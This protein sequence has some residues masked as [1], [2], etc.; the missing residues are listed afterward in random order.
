MP[1]VTDSPRKIPKQLKQRAGRCVEAQWLRCD[2]R[3]VCD[4]GQE[5][6]KTEHFWVIV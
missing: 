3:S 1:P 5:N 4:K 2:Q 6:E